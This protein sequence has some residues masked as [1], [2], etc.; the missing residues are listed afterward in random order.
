MNKHKSH[1]TK[2]AKKILSADTI[3]LDTEATGIGS[4]DEIIEIAIINSKGTPLIDELIRPNRRIPKAA[5][6]IHGIT[7]ELVAKAPKWPEVHNKVAHCLHSAKYI[8]IYNAEP[9]WRLLEQTVNQ[10]NCPTLFHYQ[11]KLHSVKTQLSEYWGNWKDHY[12]DWKWDISTAAH[13]F[14][15][16][17]GTAHRAL[18]DTVTTLLIVDALSKGV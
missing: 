1:I 2:W 7:N 18:A 13:Y 9:N 5:Q 12:T 14:D 6:A 4:K 10:Y 8:V 15:V 16:D 11:N 17:Q 3:F